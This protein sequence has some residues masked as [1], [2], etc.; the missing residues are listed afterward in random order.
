M[1]ELIDM[2]PEEQHAA[3]E[4]LSRMLRLVPATIDEPKDEPA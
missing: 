2:T 4:A 3:C 1:P